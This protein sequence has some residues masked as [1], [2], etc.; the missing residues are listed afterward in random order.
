MRGVLGGVL[1]AVIVAA[2]A[3][4]AQSVVTTAGFQYVPPTVVVDR[5][6]TLAYTNADIA[7]HNVVADDEGPDGQPLF[8]SGAPQSATTGPRDVAGVSDLAPGDYGFFCTLHPSM[9]GT[10]KVLE[11]SVTTPGVPETPDVAVA[12]PG[13]T[14]PTPSAISVD[15]DSLLAASYGTGTIFRLP[16]LEAGVLGSPTTVAQ[17]FSSPLGV[18]AAPDG[19]VFVADSHASATPGRTTAGRVTAVAPDGTKSIVVDELPNG[20]HNTNNLV[21]RAGRLYITNGNSTDDGVNGGDPEQPLSGTLLSVPVDAR[22]LN[23]SSPE[24]RVEARGMRNIYDVA[25][26]PGSDEAWIPMNGPDT[27][28]PWGEDVLNVADVG[29]SSVEDFG[30]PGC[31]YA[32]PPNEPFVKQNPAVASTDVCDGTEKPPEQLLG[33]HVSA[34]GLDFGPDEG[35]WNG[36][37]FVARFGN[38]FGDGIVGHDVVRVPIDADG[39]AG[40]PQTFLPGVTPLDVSFG[41]PGTGLY[42]ADLA[43]GILLVKG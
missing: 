42:V 17:D 14:V 8:S 3:S 30:F 4:A 27:F 18:A 22:G 10:L 6:G 19:T 16:I 9:H 37:L 33:L 25:F 40:A 26:R 21:V 28:D 43:T 23:A 11:E 35:I 1:L 20:R 41:P 24:L 31:L 36:D 13:G 15:G 29:D 12:A 7:A 39:N 5:G 34:N 38:F 2:P 32:A